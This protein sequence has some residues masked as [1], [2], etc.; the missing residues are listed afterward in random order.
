MKIVKIRKQYDA[1]RNLGIA[2]MILTLLTPA[3]D[4]FYEL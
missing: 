1:F 2:Y 3:L 4:D